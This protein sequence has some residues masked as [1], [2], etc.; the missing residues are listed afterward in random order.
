M[1]V[2]AT[3]DKRLLAAKKMPSL[4]RTQPGSYYVPERDDVL[5]WIAQQ[6][7]L[8][9]YLFELARRAGAVTYDKATGTWRGVD[10]DN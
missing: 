7:P 5:E 4:R 10:Y 9:D 6:P 2:R 1:S 8:L 3:K